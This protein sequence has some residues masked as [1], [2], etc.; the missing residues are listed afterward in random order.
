MTKE[1]G[2]FNNATGATI[3]PPKHI[4][5]DNLWTIYSPQATWANIVK[6]YRAAIG[7][8]KHG[9]KSDFNTWINTTLGQTYAEDVDK[10]E[11]ADLKKRAEDFLLQ[12]VPYG[13]LI[14]M[15]GIDV[16]KDRFELVVWA[17]GRGEEMWT[18]DY[19][20][21]EANPSIEAEWDKLDSFL[22]YKYPH[23]AGTV[24]GIE[25]A[26]LDTEGHW[27]HQAYNYSFLDK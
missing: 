27:T 7:K 8:A 11:A 9:E 6:D 18:I 10:T 19:Q 21:I 14:L 22:L 26:A 3:R 23:A 25:H 24:L 13:G 16:Q 5:F 2:Q 1:S 12:I 4:G 17:L 15:A 20:I